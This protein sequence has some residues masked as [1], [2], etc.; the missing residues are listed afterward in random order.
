V[1][2]QEVLLMLFLMTTVWKEEEQEEIGRTN[3]NQVRDSI[4]QLIYST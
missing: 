3:S 1:G 4:Q 2:T